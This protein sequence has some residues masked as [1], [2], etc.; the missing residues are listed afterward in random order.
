MP[1]LQASLLPKSVVVALR[2]G[3]SCQILEPL[4]AK[5]ADGEYSDPNLI[6]RWRYLNF[7]NLHEQNNLKV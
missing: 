3:L 7:L 5:S 6:A 4:I 2:A 1:R